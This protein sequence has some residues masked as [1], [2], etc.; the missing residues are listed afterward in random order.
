VLNYSFVEEAWEKDFC[1]N[2]APVRLL[3]PIASQMSVMR[4]SLIGSLI[5][6]TRYNLNRKLNRVRIFEIG[7]VY[8]PDTNVADGALTVAGYHQPK[9]LAS[10]AYGPVADEQWGQDTRNVDFFD[11]KADLEALFAPKSLRFAK[12]EHVALHPGRSA[13]IECDGKVIGFIGELHPRLQQK[14]DLPLA[15]VLFEV[16]ITALQDVDVPVYQEIS[17]FQPVTRDIAL[18][19]KQTVLVQNLLDVFTRETQI[20]EACKIVQAVVLF[21]EYRGKGLEADEKSLAFRVSLQDTQSTLQDDQVE[22]A[23]QALVEAAGL[24]YAAKLR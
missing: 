20:N 14:Y 1:G 21:D 4:T 18:V 23:K 22:A 11:V 8:L 5:A 3:N 17:K 9:R 15:P 16:D 13:T 7:A 24:Q 6:N 10:L 2:D 12:A 19:V